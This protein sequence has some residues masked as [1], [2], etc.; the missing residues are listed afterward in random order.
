MAFIEKIENYIDSL[1]A[2]LFYRYLIIVTGFTFLFALACV[3]NFYWT[4][5]SLKKQLNDINDIRTERVKVLLGKIEEVK[6][7][8]NEVNAI[9]AEDESFKIAGY[10]NEVLAKQGLTN[11][12]KEEIPSQ[13]DIDE[14]HRESSLNVKFTG[15]KMKQ[16]C[17]LLYVIEQK[18]R[19]YTKSLEITKSTKNPNTIDVVLTIATL[20]PKSAATE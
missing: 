18:K 20:Q 15:L 14:K 8:R 3:V 12:T 11:N 16:L 6:K 7:Q 2:K 13:T 10:F 5:G 17:E 9:L 1:E 19:I 4:I